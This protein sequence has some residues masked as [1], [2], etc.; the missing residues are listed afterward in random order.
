MGHGLGWLRT[1]IFGLKRKTRAERSKGGWLGI[2]LISWYFFWVSMCSKVERFWFVFIELCFG[3]YREPMLMGLHR[4]V[5]LYVYPYP[6]IYLFILYI[7]VLFHMLFLYIQFFILFF[8]FFIMD[9]NIDFF[10]GVY[11]S[12]CAH[13]PVNILLFLWFV[14]CVFIW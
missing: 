11:S 13:I 1:W 7:L 4:I 10:Y 9:A 12:I 2:L 14:F 6:P 5:K 3:S 8:I